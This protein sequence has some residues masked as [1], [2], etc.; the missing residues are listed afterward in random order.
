MDLLSILCTMGLP[1][2]DESLVNL[3]EAMRSTPNFFGS[4]YGIARSVGCCVALGL[5]S[6]EC[7]MMMLGRRGIDV[8]KLLRIIIISFC[9]T[10][11]GSICDSLNSMTRSLEGTSKSAA[12]G[13]LRRVA[14]KEEVVS[15]LQ[16]KY[17][18][19]LRAVQDSIAQVEKI[20]K[21]GEDASWY[22]EMLYSITSLGDTISNFTKRAALA[23]ETKISEWINDVIRFVG[24]TFFQMVLYGLLVAQSICL[25]ILKTFAPLMFALS[26]A[27]PWKSAWSQWMSKYITVGLWGYVGWVVVYYVC[28]IL[29][30]NLSLDEQA[31]MHLI[32]TTGAIDN[33][34]SQIGALGL[35]GVGTNC[36][37]V[38]GLLIGAYVL[39]MAPEIASWLIPG[40]VSS[41][42]GQQAGSTVMAGASMAA[43]GASAVAGAIG[44]R[45]QKNL[46]RD[47]TGPKTLQDKIAEG[48][49]Q[50]Q[51]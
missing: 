11:S 16:T 44:S 34:W 43:G 10:F 42:I 37:Y 18:E 29:I 8:M 33:S 22:E 45:A 30:Y 51:K 36:M 50:A 13:Q 48:I 32:S 24:M 26:L 31:Y 47:I 27:P 40:G 2:V 25:A 20:E 21:L 1:C 39:Q 5:G 15:N 23:A 41:G 12:E 19:K 7:W 3:L 17:L 9:I 4:T 38:V 28:E 14:V 35:Q 6:Y 49:K 46:T